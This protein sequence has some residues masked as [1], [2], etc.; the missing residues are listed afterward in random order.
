M[1]HVG[2]HTG[3]S[4]AARDRE[5]AARAPAAVEKVA[6]AALEGHAQD[7]DGELGVGTGEA[8]DPITER[9]ALSAPKDDWVAHAET[10]GIHTAGKTKDDLVAAVDDVETHDTAPAAVPKLKATARGTVGPAQEE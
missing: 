9:P 3:P 8:L 4:H 10:L 2:K 6:A 5:L 7:A 1:P